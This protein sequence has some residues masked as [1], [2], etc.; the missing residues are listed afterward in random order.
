MI[1][2]H[3]YHPEYVRALFNEMAQSYDRVNYITS[4]GFSLR[5]RKQFIHK[6]SSSNESLHVLDVMTGLGETWHLLLEKFPNAQIDALDYSDMMIKKATTKKE[7]LKLER[8]NLLHQNVLD[9]KLD[10]HKYDIV[11]CAFGLKTFNEQQLQLFA[12][13]VHRVLKPGGKV[14]FVEV[15]VP[16]F[17]LL[18][19]LYGFYLSKII[20]F[21]GKV[22]LGNPENYKM[23]WKY[24]KS[25]VNTNQTIKIFEEAGFKLHR[26]SYFFDCSTG[27]DGCKR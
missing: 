5:W 20:P 24:T 14:S 21:L 4:F 27:F 10:T 16:K 13:E 23:L 3:K 8:I 1:D 6:I 2:N 9:N 19:L 22:L 26:S 25:F 7:K 17:K 12:K 11:Y 15:S 18:Y